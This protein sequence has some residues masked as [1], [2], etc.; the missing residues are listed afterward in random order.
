MKKIS[1][2]NEEFKQLLKKKKKNK[3]KQKQKLNNEWDAIF[4]LCISVRL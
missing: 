2:I 4:F 1:I 3:T